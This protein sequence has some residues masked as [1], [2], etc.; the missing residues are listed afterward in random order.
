M[1]KKYEHLLIDRLMRRGVRFHPN[2]VV[3][4]ATEF[5]SNNQQ[6]SEE[7][8]IGEICQPQF[9]YMFIEFRNNK[10]SNS[11]PNNV[12]GVY[13]YKDPHSAYFESNNNYSV[14]AFCSYSG[15]VLRGKHK[16]TR[17]TF[18]LSDYVWGIS[19]DQ[20]GR[21]LRPID[22]GESCWIMEKDD[23][24]CQYYSDY[25]IKPSSPINIFWGGKE[26]LWIEELDRHLGPQDIEFVLPHIFYHPALH[27]IAQLH[28]KAEVEL[29][30]YP[31]H[32]LR[33]VE[34]ETGKEPSP[35]FMLKHYPVTQKRYKYTNPPAKQDKPKEVTPSQLP[36]TW[37]KGH[38][39]T[40][41]PTHPIPHFAGRT[42]FVAAHTRGDKK[43]GEVKKGYYIRQ[44]KEKAAK[45]T[46]STNMEHAKQD[47][48]KFIRN[49][50]SMV[51]SWG[52]KV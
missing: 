4:D 7:A 24:R 20:N 27:A 43:F 10:N 17:E 8:P 40:H 3:V 37:V 34:R 42:F 49:T 31:A 51:K 45:P 35:F 16:L 22:E 21:L 23:E 1:S 28:K 29:V 30:D 12:Y 26:F 11:Q 41:P 5:V 19:L 50:G 36:L 18:T 52:E 32:S 6:M 48:D 46:L 9:D 25:W 2:T 13:I 14:I 33:R 47:F 44:P 15:E 38:F 39:M